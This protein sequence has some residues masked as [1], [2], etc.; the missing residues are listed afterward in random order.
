[1]RIKNVRIVVRSLRD[2]LHIFADTI[3]RVR[4]GEDVIPRRELAFEDVATMRK[5][6]TE[7]RLELLNAIR[8]HQPDSVYALAHI[9]GRDIKSVN[10]DLK[11]LVKR[12][13]VELEPNNES[14]KKVK[15]IVTYDKLNV[16][17]EI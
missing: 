11:E 8:I 16:E 2:S 4:K 14:R 1:M 9:V 3:E 6:F 10:T 5:V 17:I 13:L 12:E 15:P 7:K